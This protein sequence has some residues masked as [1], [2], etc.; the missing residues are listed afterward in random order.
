MNVAF[1]FDGVLV[2][3]F[4]PLYQINVEGAK[5]VGRTITRDQY[6][7]AF[8][9]PV[10]QEL[11]RILG[12]SP[13][14]DEEFRAAKKSVFTN[15]YNEDTVSVF[16]WAKNIIPHLVKKHSMYIVTAAPSQFVTTLLKASGLAPYFDGLFGS[17][18]AGKHATLRELLRFGG[19]FV[20]D[21]VGDIVEAQNT[22]GVSL[23]VAWGFHDPEALSSAGARQVFT[24]PHLLSSYF[25]TRDAILSEK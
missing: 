6:R 11:A 18:H 16:G 7:D 13:Q 1:D 23:G 24:D 4:E 19:A 14:E 20:T 3:S 17:H 10:H 25:L 21:T 8:N 22:G 2:D 12:L 15:Y 9:G 5:A